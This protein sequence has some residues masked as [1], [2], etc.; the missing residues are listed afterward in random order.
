[1]CQLVLANKSVS[2]T[3]RVTF[4]SLTMVRFVWP[5]ISVLLDMEPKILLA[6]YSK[7]KFSELNSNDV[8][9]FLQFIGITVLF[10]DIVLVSR[11]E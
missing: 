7:E 11:M 8:S 3:R 5:V 4:S 10:V 1:M 2:L 9:K 6:F